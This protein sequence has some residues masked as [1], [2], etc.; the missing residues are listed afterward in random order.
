MAANLNSRAE[1]KRRQNTINVRLNNEAKARGVPLEVL[2]AQMVFECFL[3]R[4]FSSETSDWVVKGGTALLMR[5]GS[6]RFTRDIDMARKQPWLDVQEVRKEFERIAQVRHSDPFTFRFKGIETVRGT[7]P[8]EYKSPALRASL[9]A[10]MG[11]IEF[12][13]F[14]VDVTEQRWNQEPPEPLLISPIIDSLIDGPGNG[15]FTVRAT[16]IESHLSDKVCAM[17]EV[18]PSGIS[19]RYHDLADI[20]T[21]IQTQELV[22]TDLREKLEHESKRRGIGLPESMKSPG[23]EWVAGFRKNAPRFAGLPEGLYELNAALDYVG[24]CLNP[25]LG[26]TLSPDSRWNC[27]TQQWEKGQGS[28]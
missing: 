7:D 12:Q 5:N 3:S 9:T 20:I 10:L 24:K 28:R 8:D 17:Y 16:P 13:S 2:R 11:T 1:A 19:N 14:T 18:H 25:V 23:E 26:G 22:G 21:I 6:G 27:V 4:V 15:E